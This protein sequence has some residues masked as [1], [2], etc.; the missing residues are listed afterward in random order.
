[1]KWSTKKTLLQIIFIFVI[2][3]SCYSYNLYWYIGAAFI[4]P[5]KKVA[6][7]YKNKNK[8]INII[9][10]SGGSQILLQKIILSK[11]GDLYLPGA[12][13]FAIAASKKNMVYYSRDFIQQIPVFGLSKIGEKKILCFGDLYMKK[14]KIALGNEHTMALGKLYLRIKSK[15]PIKI[16]EGIENN[17]II[18]ATNVAQIANYLKMNIVDAGILFESVANVFKFKVISIPQNYIIID[19]A[20]LIILNFSK[21]KKISKDFFNFILSNRKIF[22]NYGYKTCF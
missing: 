13:Y 10:I 19:K 7:L 2:A 1:M 6:N 4:K 16:A 5:A 11:K 15:F 9:I 14:I 17:C 18:K 20:P 21:N 3:S 22:E 8:D 12:K